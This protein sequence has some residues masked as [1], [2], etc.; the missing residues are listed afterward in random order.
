MKKLF[1]VFLLCFAFI[2]CKQNIEEKE[3][4]KHYSSVNEFTGVVLSENSGESIDFAQHILI[5]YKVSTEHEI[6]TKVYYSNNQ[7][8]YEI[9]TFTGAV[10]YDDNFSGLYYLLNY[11]ENA[12]TPFAQ[13]KEEIKNKIV[14]IFN[15]SKKYSQ[16]K[17]FILFNE[18]INNDVEN[19]TAY[20]S[21]EYY[22]II[23][24]YNS[25]K[26]INIKNLPSTIR[27]YATNISFV[28]D[29]VYGDDYLLTTSGYLVK[30]SVS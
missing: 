6:Y 20:T 5:D 12:K 16:I 18:L 9:K 15:L 7:S 22:K 21:E 1:A 10:Y 14:S 23:N 4:I 25:K 30:L 3:Y 8:Y 27:N 13:N 24:H 2:S 17:D 11:F 28:S 29:K 26:V 19:S